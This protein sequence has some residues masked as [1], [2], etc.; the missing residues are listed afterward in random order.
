MAADRPSS[1]FPVFMATAVGWALVFGLLA[2][3]VIGFFATEVSDSFG[4]GLIALGLVIGVATWLTGRGNN[5]GRLILGLLSLI[6]AGVGLYYAF[7]GPSYALVPGLVT[8]AV[9]GGTIALLF[10]PRSSQDYFAR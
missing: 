5:I 8:A 1:P 6:T 10:V 7:S 9:A 2:F 4:G 3:G